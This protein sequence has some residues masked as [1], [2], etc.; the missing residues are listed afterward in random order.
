M[1]NKTNTCGCI[2]Q[3][4]SP[5]C[6]CE[7]GFLGLMLYNPCAELNPGASHLVPQEVLDDFM[8]WAQA[9]SD[10]KFVI[11]SDGSGRFEAVSS[12]DDADGNF[13]GVIVKDSSDGK[14]WYIYLTPE[15]QGTRLTWS[16]ASPTSGGGSC[17]CEPIPSEDVEDICKL[18]SES[19]EGN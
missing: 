10:N 17:D 15:E 7:G 5:C 16:D 14:V 1:A 6:T 11:A 13:W 18:P 4:P 19:G 2:P 12:F 8:A 9:D 3:P